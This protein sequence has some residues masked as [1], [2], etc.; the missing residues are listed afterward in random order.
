MLFIV[1]LRIFPC[2]RVLTTFFAFVWLTHHV[3][4]LRDNL[5]TGYTQISGR[6]KEQSCR[7]FCSVM[8]GIYIWLRKVPNFSL[9]SGVKLYRSQQRTH[10]EKVQNHTCCKI[11]HGSFTIAITK[12]KL[13]YYIVF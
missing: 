5:T 13:V 2:I 4:W 12:K 7:I 8:S 3:R 11:K 6:Q 1:K 10:N 9:A